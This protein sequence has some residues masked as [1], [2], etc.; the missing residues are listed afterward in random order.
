M[1]WIGLIG[2][3]ALFMAVYLLI[4]MYIRSVNRGKKKS[5]GKRGIDKDAKEKK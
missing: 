2:T 3:L 1:A 5:F 4:F